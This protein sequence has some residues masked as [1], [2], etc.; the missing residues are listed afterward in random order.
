MIILNL[1]E[2]ELYIYFFL[3]QK[4]LEFELLCYTFNLIETT[5]LFFK[6][7]VRTQY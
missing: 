1:S 3:L 6:V 4:Y 2:R 5:K 7:V